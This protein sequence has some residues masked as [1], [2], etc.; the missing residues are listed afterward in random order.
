MN[1]YLSGNIKNTSKERGLIPSSMPPHQWIGKKSN[2]HAS[3]SLHKMPAY[4][5]GAQNFM[6]GIYLVCALGEW[7]LWSS[8]GTT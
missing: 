5:L 2:R 4:E 6:A 3:C 1:I 7:M 8:N